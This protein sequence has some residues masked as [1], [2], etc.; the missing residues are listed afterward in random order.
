MSSMKS[1]SSRRVDRHLRKRLRTNPY[2]RRLCFEPLEA[3]QLLSV[4][5]ITGVQNVEIVARLTG[6]ASMNQTDLVGVGGTDLGHMVNHNGKTYFLFGDTFSGANPSIGGNWRSNVMAFTTD[7]DPSDG[8]LLDGWI[9]DN[10]GMAREVIASG[11]VTTP[12]TITEIPTGAVSIGDRIYCWYMA[13]DWWGPAG[14]W[15]ANYAGLAYWQEGDETFTVVNDFEF[16]GNGN[17]GMVSAAFRND[18]S[19]ADDDHLYIWGT[20]AGRLGGVKLA[21]VTPDQITDL[22]AYQYFDGMAGNEPTW[23]TNEYEADLI[24]NPTVGELS[25]MYNE[26]AGKWTMMYLNHNAYAI[27]MREASTPWG[28]WS[29]PLQVITGQEAPGLYGSYMNPLYVENDG[30]TVYFTMSLWNPYDV[31]VVKASLDMSPDSD[32]GDAPASYPTLLA[33]DG[34][35]HGAIGPTLGVVRDVESDGHPSTLAN[36]DDSVGM[37]NDED[38]V[39]IPPLVQDQSATLEFQVNG[40]PE[41][42]PAAWVDGWID[43]NGNETWD[44]GELVVSGS[45]HDGI[46]SVTV[47]PPANASVGSTFARFR[48]NTA[49]ALQPTG[50]AQDGE[51]EDHRVTITAGPHRDGILGRVASSGSWWFARS[52]GSRFANERVGSWSSGITWEYVLHGDFNGDGQEDIVGRDSASG[53]W[54]V[55]TSS[56][57][58]LVTKSW[59]LWSTNVTWQNVAVG[60]F[61]GDGMDDIIGRVSTSGDW[62]VAQSTGTA[63]AN[64]KWGRWSTAVTWL[65]VK[66]ADFDGDGRS[67]IAG[68][69]ETSGDWWVARSTGTALANAK[70]SR[71]TTGVDWINVAAGDF[72]GDGS[73]DLVGQV[74]HNGSWYVATSTGT[75]FANAK[76]TQWSTSVDWAD[77]NI[78]DF[79]GDG[80]SDLIGRVATS[81]K[82]YVATSTGT[83]FTNAKWGR[84][85]TAVTWLDVQVGDFDG[86]GRS[87]LAGRVSTSGDWWVARSQG[88]SFINEKWGRWSTAVEWIDVHAGHFGAPDD[89]NGGDALAVAVDIYWR[90][91]GREDDR[92]DGDSSISLKSSPIVR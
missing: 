46:H 74:S 30:E 81:G 83:A 90:E 51:V 43:W 10:G 16:S 9:T 78:G 36:G 19:G 31:Y 42:G 40:A 77:V 63:F 64:A 66:V 50:P 3:R 6:A 65:D 7:T 13:V 1:R 45:Y 88:D 14:Q 37:P 18:P 62:W 26:A 72:N 35:R 59:G 39:S 2:P 61:N 75:A 22:D 17:F 86:D 71:W 4:A 85:S 79:N 11:R 53:R 38:G 82:W 48:I 34:A 44:A 29:E 15:N 76:W 56:S 69:V 57:E 20:P 55:S 12:A 84:W 5:S 87:D 49:G 23:T 24:V 68:R 80:L 52:D 8:V 67:D 47:T 33:D 21:R 27:E 89:L 60:D 28:P 32:F 58:G 54:Y 73:M 25:V 91:I 92:D 70:W 41:G